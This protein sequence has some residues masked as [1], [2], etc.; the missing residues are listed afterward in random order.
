MPLRKFLVVGCGGSGGAALRYLM[1]QLRADLRQLGVDR[2]PPAWQ[3]VHVDAPATPD[4]GPGTLGSITDLGGRYVPV[5]NPTN[6]YLATWQNVSRRLEQG[7]ALPSLMGWAPR[8]PREANNV[9]VTD[10]AGQYRA[11]GRMLTLPYLKELHTQLEAA[12][13]DLQQPTAWGNLPARLHSGNEAVIPIVVS[14]MAGG[15]GAGI[16]LD[17]CRVLGK[18]PGIDPANLG[19]FLFTADVFNE[20]PDHARSGV[21]GNALGSLGEIIAASA[22]SGES[23][24]MELHLAHG[25]Q[26]S[27]FTSAPF[28]R[29]FPVGAMVGGDGAIFGDGSMQGIYRGIGRA[30]A[31]I[32]MSE[33]ATENYV[34]RM[35]ANR[36]PADT[37]IRSLGWGQ[38]AADFTWGSLGYASVSLGRDRYE[39]YAA[40]RI[41]RL[42]V[43]HLVH[44]HRDEVSQ[45]PDTEQLGQLVEAQWS[46]ILERAGLGWPGAEASAWF[47][48]GPFTDAQA[49]QIARRATAS[50]LARIATNRGPAMTYLSAVRAQCAAA[51][52]EVAQA[53]FEAVYAWACDW[54]DRL[55]SAVRTEFVEGMARYGLAYARA[56]ATR[57]R[58]HCDRYVDALSRA[59]SVE[60]DPLG[61]DPNLET[62][63][64]QLG[65]ADIGPGHPMEGM[66]T[67]SLTASA[68]AHCRRSAARLA[69]Q[70]L[71]SFAQDVLTALEEAAGEGLI[72]LEHSMAK[73]PS[74]AGLAHLASTTYRDWPTEAVAPARFDQA[75]NEVLV[76]SSKE[77]PGQFEA[78]ITATVQRA[79]GVYRAAVEQVRYE[80]LVGRWET[81]GGRTGEVAVLTQAARWRPSALGHDPGTRQPIPAS[82]PR[83]RAVVSTA[84]VLDRSR[85]WLARPGQPFTAFAR[86]SL[87]DYLSDPKIAQA[88][89]DER[90]DV[91]VSKF[92]EAMALARPL[93]GVSPQM[94]GA[95][96]TGQGVRYD[97]SFSE[98]GLTDGDPTAAR[99]LHQ[100]RSTASLDSTTAQAFTEALAHDDAG[101]SAA[102][103]IAVF[104]AYQKYSPLVF[105]SLLRPIQQRWTGS[106]PE[107]LRQ[108]W[109]WKRTRPLPASIAMSDAELTACAAG[110]YLGR[111]LGMI[112]HPDNVRGGEPVRVYQRT[113]ARW[114]DFPALLTSR[115]RQPLS[116]HDWMPAVLASHSL[117]LVQCNEDPTLSA[118]APFRVMRELYDDSTDHPT[119]GG[120]EMLAATRLLASWYA[121]GRW[122][123]GTASP[124]LKGSYTSAEERQAAVVEWMTKLRDGYASLYLDASGL[125]ARL[126]TSD[127]ACEAP[128][129]AEMAPVAVRSLDG[130]LECALAAGS[131]GRAGDRFAKGPDID[132]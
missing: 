131:V 82:R 127:Q 68:E 15:A 23:Q 119:R 95:V 49:G 108:I 9:P 121:D 110:W 4:V 106:S 11:I 92:F 117:A 116:G 102:T 25:L 22:R 61:L 6:S 20:L 96:H 89:R 123:S 76:T 34:D 66:I 40:Q 99:I 26:Q 93:V 109:Q 29:V 132:V 101:Q 45:L 91:F 7:K 17:A 43:D 60:V 16:F 28:A 67:A 128:L 46:Y 36:S 27:G 31:G 120:A 112:T 115:D 30:L 48:A 63:A 75:V 24:E 118:L 12:F 32:L 100:L 56:V 2:L 39:E 114:L 87:R 50:V 3:F 38:A 111:V 37:D 64:L 35:L 86:Q 107:F 122:P 78:D 55:E 85:Q 70:V 69:A 98:I 42:A 129:I 52:S 83:Y 97:Y 44:G 18:L 73:A 65:N 5:S 8:D 21:E 81:T 125:R 88:Q 58:S 33:K 74:Q 113:P 10:G 51:R 90:Q 77:F 104:G 79:A 14:S 72:D 103:R 130:L 71:T 47:R 19:L 53:A 80:I 105:A 57:L 54:A 126:E 84:D 124:I 94:V 62:R 59:G 1:D 13:R 41:A